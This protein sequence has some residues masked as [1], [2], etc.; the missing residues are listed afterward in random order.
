MRR[1]LASPVPPFDIVPA[2]VVEAAKRAFVGRIR[3]LETGYRPGSAPVTEINL[4]GVPA[5]QAGGGL[6]D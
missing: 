1:R 6:G 4:V 3:R 2:H 5:G